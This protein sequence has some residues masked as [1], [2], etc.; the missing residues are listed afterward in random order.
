VIRPRPPRLTLLTQK[1]KPISGLTLATLQ[2]FAS[3]ACRLDGTGQRSNAWRSA[4]TRR[5]PSRRSGSR[6]RQTPPAI[7]PVRELKAGAARHCRA[8]PCGFWDRGL[9]DIPRPI[10]WE[11]PGRGKEAK[12]RQ[13][14]RTIGAPRC[15]SQCTWP[16]HRASTPGQCTGPVHRASAHH[17][18]GRVGDRRGPL[19]TLG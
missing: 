17:Q 3:P 7:G 8:P 19:M 1:I 14:L 9:P 12:I 6:G 10:R 13:W 15:Q 5:D 16:V 11:L 4:M 2:K 18:I